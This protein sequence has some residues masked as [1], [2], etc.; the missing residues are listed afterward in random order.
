MSEGV[1]PLVVWLSP[2]HVG[3]QLSHLHPALSPPSWK[4][5]A[6][7]AGAV[8]GQGGLTWTEVGDYGGPEVR[9][10]VGGAGLVQDVGQNT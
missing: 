7:L 2:V 3:D 10:Q 4:D 6:E 8:V 5:Q 9:R 1:Q